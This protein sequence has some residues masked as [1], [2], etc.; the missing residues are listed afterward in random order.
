MR[1]YSFCVCVCGCVCVF[2]LSC[3]WLFVA[4]WTVA[5]QTPLSMGLSRQEYWSGLPFPTLG[6]SSQ[7][8]DWTHVSCASCIVQWI[9]YYCTTL[10]SHILFVCCWIIC[11][12]F[13]EY[14]WSVFMRDIGLFL[15]VI[16]C[17][18]M[19]LCGFD[20]KVVLGQ[21]MSWEVF[22]KNLYRIL[23]KNLYRIDIVSSLNEQ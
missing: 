18:I 19:S 20:I 4:P 8:R 1:C 6:E 7:P 13:V 22:W 14:I 11:W 2:V 21:R 23:W 3:V 12:N 9:L 17:T 15:L 10:R 5:Q 16:S